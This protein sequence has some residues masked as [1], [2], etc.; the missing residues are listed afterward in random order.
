VVADIIGIRSLAE[1]ERLCAV[2]LTGVF[3]GAAVHNTFNFQRH[4]GVAFITAGNSPSTAPAFGTED[5]V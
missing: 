4:L 1:W 2:N 3:L 5:A